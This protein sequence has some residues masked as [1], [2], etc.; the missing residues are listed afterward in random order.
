MRGPIFVVFT[1]EHLTVKINSQNKLDCTLHK[2]KK[3]L[4][5]VRKKAGMVGLKS[6][7][8]NI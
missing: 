7:Q 5:K 1:D 3:Q 8:T 4:N 2:Y 6:I